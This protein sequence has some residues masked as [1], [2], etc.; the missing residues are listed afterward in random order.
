[1]L[2]TITSSQERCF[3]VKYCVNLIVLWQFK[4]DKRKK[5]LSGNISQI[6]FIIFV[7]WFRSWI[8][9]SHKITTVLLHSPA[10]RGRCQNVVCPEVRTQP[11]SYRRLLSGPCW[12]WSTLQV[13]PYT[14]LHLGIYVPADALGSNILSHHQAKCYTQLYPCFLWVYIN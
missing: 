12:Y 14:D 3:N 4:S 10:K 8:S 5:I 2:V 13:S 11:I 1:M 7:R 6:E 9:G